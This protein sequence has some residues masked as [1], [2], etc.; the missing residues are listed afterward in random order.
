MVRQNPTASHQSAAIKPSCVKVTANGF[1]WPSLT[2][3]LVL[4]AE[5]VCNNTA[6]TL[7]IPTYGLSAFEIEPLLS[8]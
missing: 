7:Q 1:G 4:V 6:V 5:S 2:G 8:D 3:I